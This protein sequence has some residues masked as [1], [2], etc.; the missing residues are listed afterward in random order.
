M[1]LKPGT[2]LSCKDGVVELTAEVVD[3]ERDRPETLIE[4]IRERIAEDQYEIMTDPAILD[5]DSLAVASCVVSRDPLPPGVHDGLIS[6]GFEPAAT[7]Q[8]GQEESSLFSRFQKRSRTRLDRWRTMYLRARDLTPRLEELEAS[9]IEELPEGELAEIAE[10]AAQLVV[11]GARTFFQALLRPD[12]SG[13]ESLETLILAD[14]AT[15]KGRWV[16]HPKAV[17]ALAAFAG[18]AIRGEAPQT[19]WT[20]DEE[21]PLHVTVPGG[22]IVRSDPQVRVVALVTQG[23]KAAL[24]EYARSVIQQSQSR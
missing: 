11:D 24:G 4:A 10:D 15:K 13:L 12:L 20:E 1:P 19:E 22:V 16:L 3:G 23:R 6:L 17:R 21:A 5:P 8:G 7:E 18:E 2:L 14:R 9:L